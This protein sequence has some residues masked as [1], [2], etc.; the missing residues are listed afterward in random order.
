MRKDYRM[1]AGSFFCF[2]YSWVEEVSLDPAQW[3]AAVDI[4]HDGDV[5]CSLTSENGRIAITSTTEGEPEE[6]TTTLHVLATIYAPDS[7]DWSAKIARYSLRLFPP[8]EFGG[9]RTQ[10]RQHGELSIQEAP[11]AT[12]L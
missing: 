4:I 1:I 11:A 10:V 5:L 7:K 3:K 9:N 8:G 2:E 6:Q 12:W